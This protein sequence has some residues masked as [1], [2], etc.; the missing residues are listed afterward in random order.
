MLG[1]SPVSV[2]PVSAFEESIRS[3]FR[4]TATVS[5]NP[6]YVVYFSTED[7]ITEPSD[8]P[9]NTPIE[10]TL[11]TALHYQRSIVGGEYGLGRFQSGFGTMEIIASDGAKD[12]LFDRYRPDGGRV[13]LRIMEQGG[14]LSKSFLAFDGVGVRWAIS[15]DRGSITVKDNSYKLDVP[16][17]RSVYAGTGGLEGGTDLAGKRRPWPLGYV[18]NIPGALVIPTE[19]LYD[20]SDGPIQ[21]VT[22]CRDR[23]AALSFK[24]DYATTALLRSSALTTSQYGTCLAEGRARIGGNPSSQ[25]RFDVQGDNLGGFVASTADICRRL[26]DVA[27]IMAVPDGLAAGTFELVN[28]QQP[29][30]IG[31]YVAPDASDTVADVIEKL[32][33][34]VGGWAGCRAQGKFEIGI[35]LAPSSSDVPS[36]IYGAADGDILS[37]DRQ[38]LPDFL[39]P[40]PT[41]WRIAYDRNWS[42][43]D[44][45]AGSVAVVD[46]DLA[47]WLAK[48]TR[49]ALP[50]IPVS[51]PSGQK[52]IEVTKESYFRDEVDAVAEAN[53]CLALYRQNFN[54]YVYKVKDHIFMHEIG[55]DVRVTHPRFGLGAG[56]PLRNVSIND[57]TDDNTV[58]LIGFG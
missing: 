50:S 30:P 31:Y 3:W 53:R 28:V 13:A 49:Y 51:V 41:S 37:I 29:A 57:N 15:R 9:A 12:D 5:S 46:P 11:V 39:S 19:N 18:R 22:A 25:I 36:F 8:L 56:R 26:I 44:D 38:P 23:G 2:F 1:F 20:L 43:Q 7:F 54:L 47:A 55:R 32:M 34:S 48:D 58:E 17:Q 21:A 52:P 45:I 42:K 10:G 4:A 24:A 6:S 16:A 33:A 27:T 40:P 35:L 14:L